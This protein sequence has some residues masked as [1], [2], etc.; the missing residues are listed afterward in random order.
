MIMEKK[1]TRD[2]QSAWILKLTGAAMLTA[3]VVVLQLLGSFIHFGP[4]SVSLVLA[5]ITLGAALFGTATSAWLGLVFG[6][7]VLLSGDATFFMGYHAVGTVLTVLLKGTLAGLAA[8][9]VYR[10]VEKKNRYVATLL[11]AV[12]CPLVNTGIFLLGCRVFLWDAV[13]DLGTAQGFAN[14]AVFAIV[15]L[16]GL[17]FIAEFVLNCV[18]TPAIVR[19]VDLIGSRFRAKKG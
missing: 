7:T 16:V 10:L 3:I 2:E 17:N 13:I 4:V 1:M 5:P 12:V 6:V 9:F 8:G 15:G 14:A 11:A 18:L 19:L